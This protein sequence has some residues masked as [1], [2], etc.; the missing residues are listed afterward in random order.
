MLQVKN[1]FSNTPKSTTIEFQLPRIQQNCG[2]RGWVRSY[3]NPVLHFCNSLPELSQCFG[4][5]NGPLLLTKRDFESAG[6][7]TRQ[8]DRNGFKPFLNICFRFVQ[9][10]FQPLPLSEQFIA[11]GRMRTRNSPKLVFTPLS[12][13]LSLIN[14]SVDFQLAV[15]FLLDFGRQPLRILLQGEEVVGSI[16]ANFIGFD[17]VDD[18]LPQVRPQGLVH[19]DVKDVFDCFDHSLAL[20]VFFCEFLNPFT[21]KKEKRCDLGRKGAAQKVLKRFWTVLI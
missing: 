2:G 20:L 11:F 18:V 17:V 6:E 5:D 8:Q 9:F 19:I 16:R 13:A 21:I 14:F 12:L 3:E 7:L 4:C 15:A 1:F 10:L